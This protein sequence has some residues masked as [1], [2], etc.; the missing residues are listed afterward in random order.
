MWFGDYNACL[1]GPLG[2]YSL[3]IDLVW[4]LRFPP[5]CSIDDRRSR[6]SS[7]RGAD[8]LSFPGRNLRHFLTEIL[9]GFFVLCTHF[10]ENGQ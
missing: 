2:L 6:A 7:E 9:E 5:F 8:A 10:L 1:N 3:S 4:A